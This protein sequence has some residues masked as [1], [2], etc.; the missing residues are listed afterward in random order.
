MTRK[1]YQ[2]I[3]RVIS[4]T[5]RH[6]MPHNEWQYMVT[7]LGNLFAVDNHLFDHDKWYN[8][9]NTEYREVGQQ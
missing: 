1:D 3:A 2:A 6:I 7:R 8:A 9:C 5:T 4:T